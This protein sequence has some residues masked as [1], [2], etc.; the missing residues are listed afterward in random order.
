MR[1]L[2]DIML[3][4]GFMDKRGRMYQREDIETQI[5][6]KPFFGEL[7]SN[8]ELDINLSRVSHSVENLVVSDRGLSGDIRILDTPSGKIAEAL[9]DAGIK[10][11]T[12]IRATGQL[13]EDL[14]VR[15]LTLI[16]FDLTKEESDEHGI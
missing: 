7:D 4:D 8:H 6:D 1:V 5:R 16:T 9:L 15:D 13:G 14:R 12:S 11:R 10:L 3:L 2:K